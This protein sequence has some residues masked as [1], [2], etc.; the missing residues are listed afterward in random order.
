MDKSGGFVF[1][2]LY[3]ISVTMLCYKM[4]WGLVIS[5]HNSNQGTFFDEELNYTSITICCSEM[6]YSIEVIIYSLSRSL[7]LGK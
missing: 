6:W 7:F 3:Y 2:K 4:Q 5:I 1:K